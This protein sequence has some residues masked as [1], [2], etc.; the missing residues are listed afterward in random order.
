[1]GVDGDDGEE[2]SRMIAETGGKGL[3]SEGHYRGVDDELY[4]DNGSQWT[5]GDSGGQ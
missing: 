3:R 1:V 4:A 5:M 2:V